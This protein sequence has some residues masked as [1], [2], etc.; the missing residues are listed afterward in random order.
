MTAITTSVDGAYIFGAL[1][2]SD[3]LPVV[4]RAERPDEYDTPLTWAEAYAPGA[5]TAVNII[6]VPAN[7]DLMIFYGNFGTDVCVILHTISAET[8]DD[9]SPSSAGAEV[10]NCLAVNPSDSDEM[11]ATIDTSEDLLYT[12]DGGANWSIINAA[13][14]FAATSMAV[15]WGGDQEP[16]RVFVGGN[17]TSDTLLLFSPNNGTVTASVGGATLAAVTNIAGIE[18]GYVA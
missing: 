13:L 14:G 5:G 2:D 1:E 15:I 16:H 4:L 17:D 12:S 18:A 6:Q 7:S 10:I 9:I 11:I 8:N 3:G